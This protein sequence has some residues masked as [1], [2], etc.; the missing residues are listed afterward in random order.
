MFLPPT[1]YPVLN[2][3]LCVTLF[4]GLIQRKD[5]REKPICR[6]HWL[7]ETQRTW[8][9]VRLS[10]YLQKAPEVPFLYWISFTCFDK[11]HHTQA[12][13]DVTR[14]IFRRAAKLTTRWLGKD[15]IESVWFECKWFY[16]SSIIHGNYFVT[17]P[18][19]GHSYN[20]RLAGL[21][22]ENTE[23]KYNFNQTI[24]LNYVWG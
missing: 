6:R 8:S 10:K 14:N 11:H 23:S 18:C 24:K 21:N 9:E 20:T 12:L 15:G 17:Y 1:L 16:T 13:N 5:G 22:N 7:F 4:A 2:G 19:F 3:V